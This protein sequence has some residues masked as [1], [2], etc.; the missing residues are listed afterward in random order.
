MVVTIPGKPTRVAQLQVRETELHCT[1][2][3]LLRP[4]RDKGHPCKPRV[5]RE[6]VLAGPAGSNRILVRETLKR[7]ERVLLG[8]KVPVRQDEL[9]AGD[10]GPWVVGP[11]PPEARDPNPPDFG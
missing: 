11:F 8:K 6:E 7:V 5:R 4:A 3:L 9:Q 10:L 1:A 2:F